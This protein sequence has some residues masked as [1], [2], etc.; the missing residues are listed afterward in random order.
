[1]NSK[2][3]RFQTE[4]AAYIYLNKS[5]AVFFFSA[6]VV[7]CRECNHTAF[8]HSLR[9][10]VI[11]ATVWLLT[12]SNLLIFTMKWACTGFF[13]FLHCY[14]WIWWKVVEERKTPAAEWLPVFG[15]DWT[16]FSSVFFFIFVNDTSIYTN[17]NT[18]RDSYPSVL[19]ISFL[20]VDRKLVPYSFEN[21]VVSAA[22]NLIR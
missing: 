3:T 7:D 15:F 14:L 8:G 21:E 6:V 4:C 22:S 19:R 1:M 10:I 11:I 18:F 13:C 16:G 17:M 20:F 5:M 12:R 2:W 9:P